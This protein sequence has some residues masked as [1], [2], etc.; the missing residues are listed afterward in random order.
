MDEDHACVPQGE[1]SMRPVLLAHY[2]TGPVCPFSE[3]PVPSGDV[4]SLA[5]LGFQKEFL[6]VVFLP[7]L[8]FPWHPGTVC[9]L[10]HLGGRG[11]VGEWELVV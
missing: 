5:L 1:A 3:G 8:Q 10:W 6:F 11:G 7:S 4:C 2:T 9:V